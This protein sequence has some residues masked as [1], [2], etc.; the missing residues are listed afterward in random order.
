MTD[1]TE[2]INIPFYQKVAALGVV[3]LI[4]IIIFAIVGAVS[5]HPTAQQA[6]DRAIQ[7]CGGSRFS[8]DTDCPEPDYDQI[9]Y[10]GSKGC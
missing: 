2:E 7:N 10:D 1:K 6:T 5:G 8:S 4:A 3:V 9:D